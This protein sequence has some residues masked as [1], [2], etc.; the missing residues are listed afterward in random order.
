MELLTIKAFKN[1]NITGNVWEMLRQVLNYISENI[2]SD[3]FTLKD[4]GNSN[5]DLVKKMSSVD[6]YNLSYRMSLII[7]RVED[8]SQNL[9]LYF[10]VNDNYVD[11]NKSDNSYGIK[12]GMS[13]FSTPPNNE[14]FG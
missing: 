14:R 8:N 1:N 4:P 10:P 9:K 11:Q 13:D 3:N 7:E 5:N 6:R 12:T 2:N